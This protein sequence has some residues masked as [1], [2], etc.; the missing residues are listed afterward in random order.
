[1]NAAHFRRL[2]DYNYW[3][4]KLV[5]GCTIELS[6][7]Q[8]YH[9]SDFS[10]GSVHEQLVHTMFAESLWLERAKG[11]WPNTD[12]DAK[13]YPTREAIRSKWDEV[14]GNWRE[15]VGALRDEQLEDIFT[16]ISINGKAKREIAQWEALSTIINHSTD[17]RAQTMALIHQLGGKTVEQDFVFYTWEFPIQNI[18]D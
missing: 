5:W 2:F 6:D 7:E 15:Y 12:I 3:A 14:E 11:I 17:H 8:F 1:M 10:V 13:D 16:F 9:P 4:H 18:K